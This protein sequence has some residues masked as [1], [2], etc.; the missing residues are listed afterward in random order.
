MLAHNRSDSLARYELRHALQ[1]P[2]RQHLIRA[3][4]EIQILFPKQ[5]VHERE[6]L[7]HQLVLPHVVPVLK[8][9]RE[10][11][12]VGALEVQQQWVKIALEHGRLVRNDP[13]DL[14]RCVQRKGEGLHRREIVLR[15]GDERSELLDLLRPRVLRHAQFPRTLREGIDEQ[16][17]SPH[18]LSPLRAAL[19]L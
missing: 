3:Q 1:W 9:D 14:D 10:R 18:R 17:L 12:A 4:L 11:R 19:A 8:D 16:A 6:E 7:Y 13:R 2:R 5:P 15:I